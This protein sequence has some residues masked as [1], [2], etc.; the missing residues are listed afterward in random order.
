MPLVE[1][2]LQQE[3]G[4]LPA[5]VRRTAAER[6]QHVAVIHNDRRLSY[7]EL[8]RLMDRIAA[9]LARDGVRHGD[10]IS[11]CATTSIEYLATFLGALR[12]GVAVAPLAPSSTPESLGTMVADA[13]AK[14]F[15]LDEGVAAAIDG[16]GVKVTAP[17]VALDGSRA[18]TAFSEWL[19]P[20]G[21]T[22][23]P[24]EIAPGDAFNI[25]YSSGTTGAPKGIVQ[26]HQ[27]RWAHIRFGLSLGY[28]P[29][30]ITLL[31]TPLYSN[32]TLVSIIPTIAG[33]GTALLMEKFDVKRF[34]ELAERH[35]ATHA[36][37]VPVQYK[38]LMEYPDFD[39]Y[40]L[41]S[42]RMKFCTSAPFAAALKADILR[43][44]PG[45]LMSSV[46]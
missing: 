25:I 45:G 31:S 36:M 24:V 43:R 29:D 18:G 32:T 2:V 30:S 3:F 16:A 10:A 15:F 26:S 14:V 39:R 22:P 21:A 11:I 19:A 37:L 42:F 41:S 44:W 46:A 6:P 23:E 5:L 35:R 1:D 27:M 9:A 13:G 28:R 8:D 4:T 34:L 17:R 12:A 40:D 7:A 33:G 20:E 38:R